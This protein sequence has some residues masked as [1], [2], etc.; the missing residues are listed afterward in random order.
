MTKMKHTNTS[1]KSP[2]SS[3]ISPSPTSSS[4]QVLKS[5][6]SWR[7][8]DDLWSLR[9]RYTDIR[10]VCSGGRSVSGHQALLAL[11]S[12][13]LKRLFEEEGIRE[14]KRDPEITLYT[15]RN[16][17]ILS[18]L[19]HA[20]SLHW[21]PPGP[22]SPLSL[23][24]LES[25]ARM[26]DIPLPL[27]KASTKDCEVEPTRCIHC[28]VK[29]QKLKPLKR[30]L[31]SCQKAG[32]TQ[33][34]LCLRSCSTPCNKKQHQVP[35]EPMRVLRTRSCTLKKAPVNA[36]S[37]SRASPSPHT[38][39]KDEDTS[40]DP[41]LSVIVSCESSETVKE[42]GLEP[43]Q[44]LTS[45]INGTEPT[46]SERNSDKYR[47]LKNER[48]FEEMDLLG[49]EK[50][51]KQ[52]DETSSKSNTSSNTPV[53]EHGCYLCVNSYAS[54]P[55]LRDHLVAHFKDEL[56]TT[57]KGFSCGV[58][59]CA[60]CHK[61]FRK[62]VIK[63]VVVRHYGITHLFIKNYLD[64]EVFDEYFSGQ[65]K[66]ME[67]RA[68]KMKK[69]E[70][71]K[72]VVDKA[73]IPLPPRKSLLHNDDGVI[74]SYGNE[75][76]GFMDNDENAI[77]PPPPPAPLPALPPLPVP[78]ATND[79]FVPPP[80]ATQSNLYAST[81]NLMN[82]MYTAESSFD[83]YPRH[84]HQEDTPSRDNYYSDYYSMPPHSDNNSSVPHGENYFHPDYEPQPQLHQHPSG[85]G[86]GGENQSGT[87]YGAPF[88]Y[89]DDATYYPPCETTNEHPIIEKLDT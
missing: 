74:F 59:T 65:K 30:H 39:I 69:Q 35:V 18:S 41:I 46:D 15:R 55:L 49:G 8:V 1:K 82:G 53:C 23:Y 83:R 16:R 44:S 36:S 79:P 40:D 52:D 85:G 28:G 2:S 9:D 60:I 76:R 61:E 78:P 50:R 67:R 66:A 29:F 73:P 10:L 33:Q 43:T 21:E 27:L 11:Y 26:L 62:P 5:S 71:E 45:K 3:T 89:Y 25:L 54:P 34:M 22:L 14:G 48:G 68:L 12:P 51:S 56:W 77:A 38:S 20:A 72:S 86:G 4:S 81:P 7:F 57:I 84:H 32:N 75:I 42:N 17:R 64:S 19:S 37:T 13:F 87:F 24:E 88:N 31:S 47:L 6:S 70:F 58:T 63:S 80:P